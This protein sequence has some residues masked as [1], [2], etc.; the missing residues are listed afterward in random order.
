VE[1][2]LNALGNLKGMRSCFTGKPAGFLDNRRVSWRGEKS[3]GF[4]PPENRAKLARAAT[5]ERGVKIG[6]GKLP[7]AQPG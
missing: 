2:C 3:A 5:Q 1:G 4:D 6:P 7:I